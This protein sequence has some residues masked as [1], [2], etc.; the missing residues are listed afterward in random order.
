[1]NPYLNGRKL[2]LKPNQVLGKGGEADIFRLTKTTALKLFKGADHPDYQGSPSLQTAAQNRLQEHQQKLR[3]F[4]YGLPPQVITPQDFVTDRS[5][6][7]ILG[8]TM[9]LVRASEPLL[10]YSDR[11]F[12][13]T[14]ITTLQILD[15]FQD[16]HQTLMELHR[17]GVILGDFNDLN[18]LIQGRSAHIIDIDSC[19]FG[20]FLC[21]VFSDRFLDP[22]LADVQTQQLRLTQPYTEEADW[23][24]FTVMLFQCLLLVHPYGGVYRPQNPDDRLPHGQRPLKRISVFHPDVHYPKPALP[25]ET[26]SD[27]LLHHFQYVFHQDGRGVFPSHFL[28]DLSWQS[29]PHCGLEYSRPK[30]PKCQVSTNVLTQVLTPSPHPHQSLVVLTL[31]Q[32]QGQILHASLQG[33]R[34]LWLY[35]HQE[36]LYR[37]KGNEILTGSW[38]QHLQV[39]IQGQHTLLA[40]NGTLIKLTP[41]QAPQSLA[42]EHKP[43]SSFQPHAL[44]TNQEHTYWLYQGQL[45]R[46]GDWGSVY[47]GDVLPD[48]TY[49]WVGDRLG[50]GFY[51]AGDL[52]VSFLFDK[53]KPGLNDRLDL[54]LGSG[55]LLDAITYFGDD[56]IWV[57]WAMQE[58]GQRLNHCALLNH[59]GHVLATAQGQPGDGSWL[60]R[61]HG[62]SAAGHG[63]LVPLDE[64]I[65]RVELQQGC[66]HLSTVF[67]ATEPFVNS[68]ITL[69]AGHDGLYGVDRQHILQFKLTP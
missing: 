4:P 52:N 21:R 28:Q 49:I 60:D 53:E 47:M 35:G 8:Y 6:R 39:A 66:L 2:T 13:Q 16:L 59:Q 56:R 31:F 14:G 50:F 48:Q 15:I 43:F 68:H 51:R 63:L 30:C 19:Q 11:S 23:Y 7:Q 57:F 61:L 67:T 18:V 22:L 69:F 37:E 25:L 45:R 29:C 46:D 3:Q 41:G 26:L 58:Q 40:K 42:V 9:S 32:T 64:G 36:H 62:K 44:A 33:S 54:R 24:A 17:L 20:P 1:M 65:G 5:G 38:D 27:E 34:L 10:R 12:R 55:Q